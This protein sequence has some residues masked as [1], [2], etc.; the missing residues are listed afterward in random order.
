M[1]IK[2]KQYESFRRGRKLSLLV[3]TYSPNNLFV[4]LEN[5]Y[6]LAVFRSLVR[7]WPLTIFWKR[8]IEKEVK[9]IVVNLVK[10]LIYIFNFWNKPFNVSVKECP[11]I[12]ASSLYSS[13]CLL[14]KV[15]GVSIEKWI[16]WLPLPPPRSL[17]IRAPGIR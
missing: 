10:K 8:Q 14:F 3:P 1:H 16:M 15:F 7:L 12:S 17:G 2:V 5:N 6:Q 13:F 11:S 9:K 4:F